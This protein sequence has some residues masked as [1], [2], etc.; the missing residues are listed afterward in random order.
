[1]KRNGLCVLQFVSLYACNTD[2]SELGSTFH[3]W[4]ILW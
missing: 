3:L 4:Y 1:M 2:L